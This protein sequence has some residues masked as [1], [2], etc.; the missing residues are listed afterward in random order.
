MVDDTNHNLPPGDLMPLRVFSGG[1]SKDDHERRQVEELLLLLDREFREDREGCLVIVNLKL[2]LAKEN[3]F[4]AV[5]VRRGRFVVVDLKDWGGRIVADCAPG[6]RWTLQAEDGGQ[7]ASKQK[8]PFEQARDHRDQLV[9]YLVSNVLDQGTVLS[10]TKGDPTNTSDL[11]RKAS[12]DVVSWV[13]V[14]SGSIVT[15]LHLGREDEKWFRIVPMDELPRQVSM[16]RAPRELASP[17][18]IAQAANDLGVPERLRWR[19]WYLPPIQAGAGIELQ[20]LLFAD[21]T[22]LLGSE[23]GREVLRGIEDVSRLGLRGYLPELVRLSDSQS[24]RIAYRALRL[25]EAW[26]SELPRDREVRWLEANDAERRSWAFA[27]VEATKNPLAESA[28]RRFMATGEPDLQ[29]LSLRLLVA[30]ERPSTPPFLLPLAL[31]V[32]RRDRDEELGTL[33]LMIAGM[34]VRGFADAIPLLTQVV[35]VQVDHLG[36]EWDNRRSWVV[37]ESIEA[38]SRVDGPEVAGFLTSLLGLAEGEWDY[39]VIRGLGRLGDQSLVGEVIPYLDSDQPQIFEE[40]RTAL[41]RIGGEDSFDAL[42]PSYLE[43]VRAAERTHELT[44]ALGE[45]DRSLFERRILGILEAGGESPQAVGSLL[46]S[47]MHFASPRSA[48]AVFPYLSD[49]DTYTDAC[50]VLSMPDVYPVI[51][52][53]ARALH[54]SLNDVER[55]SHVYLTV[56]N[57][58]SM[59][60]Q[61]L[62]PHEKD[63]SPLVR[64]NVVE[65]YSALH[66]EYTHG[67]LDLMLDD[68]DSEVRRRA[69]LGLLGNAGNWL[70]SCHV[71]IGPRL[72]VHT[73]AVARPVGVVVV[74]Q[75]EDRDPTPTFVRKDQVKSIHLAKLEKLGPVAAI[76]VDSST[77]GQWMVISPRGVHPVV[78]EREARDWL[79]SAAALGLPLGEDLEP[80][81]SL[82]PS[83]VQT[84]NLI[85]DYRTGKS[86]ADSA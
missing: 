29:R 7:K 30:L 82:H 2:P 35:R 42:W 61:D 50:N 8:N 21:I 13:V 76:E 47:L 63:S 54:D 75:D 66:S 16:E 72:M 12:F 81:H 86:R 26:G 18:R 40:A 70:N 39:A 79:A 73:E 60:V 9:D 67:R 4:D 49:V 64:R 31:E 69:A 1:P 10:L 58:S 33:G 46:W 74:S 55:A 32:A 68:K 25:L 5:I 53:R 28:L 62:A 65:V 20:S 71:A 14:H 84:A 41:Q 85:D 6:A 17:D 57:S 19:D 3:Q 27:R 78:Q 22:R 23:E 38:L 77:G 51:A 11:K 44:E 52:D 34:G 48:P 83:L 43:R 36:R 80:N 45:I 37:D 15:P 56:R 24:F 59:E